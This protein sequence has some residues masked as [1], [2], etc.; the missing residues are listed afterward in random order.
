MLVLSCACQRRTEE[1]RVKSVIAA[2]QQAAEKKE[3]RTILG[4]LAKTYRDPQGNDY[5]G[6]KGLLAFYFFRHPRVSVFIPAM[7][8]TIEDG[9]ARARFQA[10]LS[11]GGEPDPVG[12]LLP[13][14]LGVYD[15]DV[16]FT[17]MDSEWKVVSAAWQREPAAPD[18]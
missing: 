18:P 13:Q 12:A 6:I 2:V 1:D 16:S 5:D 4:S 3:V 8:V 9:S 15:F 17:K 7:D 11:G 14:S 10:V